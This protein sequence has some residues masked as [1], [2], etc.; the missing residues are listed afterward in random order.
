MNTSS[1]SIYQPIDR[2]SRTIRLVRIL[3]ARDED[4]DTISC[5]FSTFELAQCPPYVALSYARGPPDQGYTILVDNKP[6]I[7]RENLRH[8][9]REIRKKVYPSTIS[10]N[11]KPLVIGENL[12]HALREIQNRVYTSYLEPW[13]CS[14]KKHADPK[15][16]PKQ[17]AW[18]FFWIDALC[19]NQEDVAERNHQ[20][21]MMSSIYSGATLVLVWLG[22]E[23]DYSSL[24]MKFL[25]RLSNPLIRFS[26]KQLDIW[27]ELHQGLADICNR[28]YWTRLWTVQELLLARQLVLLCGTDLACWSGLYKLG[29]RPRKLKTFGTIDGWDAMAALGRK[30]NWE[31]DRHTT[32]RRA[33]CSW[34]LEKLGCSD[35]RDRLF[36]LLGLFEQDDLGPMGLTAA[37]YSKSAEQIYSDVL[38]HLTRASTG[39]ASENWSFI[40]ALM[41]VLRLNEGEGAEARIAQLRMPV[42]PLTWPWLSYGGPYAGEANSIETRP[43]SML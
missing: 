1:S 6:L 43:F 19:I 17:I 2:T 39:P 41:R 32:F 28:E 25:K 21:N 36:G 29:R 9:L 42:S 15:I 7:V 10:V 3:P 40:V 33:V 11:N 20:V 4:P 30:W 5:S 38:S 35:T 37:D 13:T 31:N 23:G 12:R 16:L 14:S 18:S 27:S 34:N 8:A 24:A 22:V 26:R